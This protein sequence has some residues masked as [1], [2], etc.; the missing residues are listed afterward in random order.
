MRAGAT[1]WWAGAR[2]AL[3][4]T[5][6]GS[7]ISPWQLE[8]SRDG[9]VYTTGITNTTNQ[10]SFPP[11]LPKKACCPTFSSIPRSTAHWGENSEKSV[12][13]LRIPMLFTDKI[14]G[15][16]FGGGRISVLEKHPL[17]DTA[18]SCHFSI[19]HGFVSHLQAL[20]EKSLWEQV[21]GTPGTLT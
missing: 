3:V 10:G 12:F 21:C 18:L 20:K 11:H 14:F 19:N 8:A 1:G 17:M 6:P 7:V 5:I 16:G 13:R 2:R 4:F 15:W 9:S